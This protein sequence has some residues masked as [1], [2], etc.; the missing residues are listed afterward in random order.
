MSLG[1]SNDYIN[2][3]IVLVTFLIFYGYLKYNHTQLKRQKNWNSVKCNPLEMVIGS[4]FDYKNSNK[5]FEKCMQYSVSNEQEER[6]KNHS[7]EINKNLQ[8]EIN[9]LN[10][11]S[12]YNSDVADNILSDTA[13]E[14]S[15]LENESL[16][17]ETTINNLKLK[18]EQWNEKINNAFN[19]IR[20]PSN[21]VV[22]KLEL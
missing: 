17:N 12:T 4:I 15:K 8:T 10:A 2:R 11:E 9:N 18:V 14:I 19:A 21:D 7:K 13:D 1:Y 20:D 3:N 6:I 5:N 22:N 16:D